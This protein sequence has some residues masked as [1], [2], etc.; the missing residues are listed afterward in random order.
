MPNSGVVGNIPLT[1]PESGLV[2][3]S[4]NTDLLSY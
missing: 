1:T 2:L 4:S 3:I